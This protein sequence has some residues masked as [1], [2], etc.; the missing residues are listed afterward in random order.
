MQCNVEV[1]SSLQLMEI[2]YRWMQDFYIFGHV[3]LSLFFFPNFLCQIE[4]DQSHS[5]CGFSID[6]GKYRH[7][8]SVLNGFPLCASFRVKISAFFAMS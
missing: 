4:I 6:V 7:I 1:A 3:H 5:R 2:I 8:E